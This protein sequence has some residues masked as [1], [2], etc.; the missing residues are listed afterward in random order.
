MKF[1]L[2]LPGAARQIIAEMVESSR[3]KFECGSRLVVY[4]IL[5]VIYHVLQ[6]YS[7]ANYAQRI[8]R[9]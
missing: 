2:L 1:Y 6:Y 5:H 9:Q 7:S 3:L 8:N 4:F